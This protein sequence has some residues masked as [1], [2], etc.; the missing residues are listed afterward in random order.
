MRQPAYFEVNSN[1][2]SEFLEFLRDWWIGTAQPSL[3]ET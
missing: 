2:S 1:F 3:T